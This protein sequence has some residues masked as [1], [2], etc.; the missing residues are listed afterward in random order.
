MFILNNEFQTIG[1][2]NNGGELC[3]K[4]DRNSCEQTKD[5]YIQ[6]AGANSTGIGPK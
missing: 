1:Y 6:I 5:E 3:E 4:S 2:T